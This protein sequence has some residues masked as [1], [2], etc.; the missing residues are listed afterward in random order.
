MHLNVL[1]W[2]PLHVHRNYS[3]QSTRKLISHKFIHWKSKIS[4]NQICLDSEIPECALF[5]C[6]LWVS[7]L[8]HILKHNKHCILRTSNLCLFRMCL[9]MFVRW[10]K[11]SQR[12]SRY[13]SHS[14]KMNRTI[15][16]NEKIQKLNNI[17]LR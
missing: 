17:Q 6:T 8:A 11:L 4:P 14:S 5:A 12:E 15:K 9:F 13:T 3:I 10:E 7:G 16:N 1:Q 2:I